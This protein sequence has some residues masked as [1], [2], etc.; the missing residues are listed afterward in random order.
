MIAYCCPATTLT[1]GVKMPS[2][3]DD[4]LPGEGAGTLGIDE[5]GIVVVP[6]APPVG[7]DGPA[8]RICIWKSAPAE[9][10]CLR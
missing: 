3:G 2:T 1:P 6:S 7:P 5:S 10:R 9:Q 8:F 4:G